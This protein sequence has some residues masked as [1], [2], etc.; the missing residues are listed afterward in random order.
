M[1]TTM[2]SGG[3]ETSHAV[4][5]AVSAAAECPRHAASGHQRIV[6]RAS[7]AVAATT[8]FTSPFAKESARSPIGSPSASNATV[9][10]A[11]LSSAYVTF[12]V[13]FVGSSATRTSESCGGVAHRIGRAASAR[14]AIDARRNANC[15]PPV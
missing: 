8:R 11:S 4:T 5:R 13:R 9:T 14:K 15:P 6:R 12:T 1:S 3:V 7:P 10:I 2:M